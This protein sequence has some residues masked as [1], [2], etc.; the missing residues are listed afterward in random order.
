MLRKAV[1]HIP[2]LILIWDIREHS[3]EDAIR[4]S[5]DDHGTLLKGMMSHPRTGEPQGPTRVSGVTPRFDPTGVTKAEEGRFRRRP[6]SET[7]WGL[8]AEL[9][10][11]LPWSGGC[12]SE[13]SELKTEDK[14]DYEYK[15][16]LNTKVPTCSRQ[17][18]LP[19]L[20]EPPCP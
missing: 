3:G 14:K 10:N 8:G 19:A 17:V 5:M 7:E 4:T 13:S 18:P 2:K 6:G 12:P 11:I 15:V 1:G 20:F 9:G 16:A